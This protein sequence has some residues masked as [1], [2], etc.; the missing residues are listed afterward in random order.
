MD[1]TKDKILDV[2]RDLFMKK[3]YD[4]TSMSAIADEVG[5]NKSSLYYFF[6]DKE[7]LYFE[8]MRS[9]LRNIIDYLKKVENTGKYNFA[10]IIENL[11]KISAKDS[12]VA[13][14]LDTDSIDHKSKSMLEIHR[15]VAEVQ[16][17]FERI[18]KKSG[19][20]EPH[21]SSEVTLNAIHAYAIKSSCRSVDIGPKKYAQYLS[22]LLDKNNN[23]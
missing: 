21:V 17:I 19:D 2:S 20:K 4:A 11:I 16:E 22:K 18:C 23:K 10:N 9:A 14:I 15:G 7:H 13:Y 1:K 12:I 6:K 8:I 5:I 3:G